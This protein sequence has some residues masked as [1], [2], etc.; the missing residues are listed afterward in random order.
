MTGIKALIFDLDNTLLNFFAFKRAASKAALG[1]M[2]KNGLVVKRA[3]AEKILWS[4]YYQYGFEYRG[5]FQEFLK[6]VGHDPNDLRLVAAAA[7]AYR[8][9]RAH[10][11]KTYPAVRPTLRALRKRG[12]KLWIVTDAPG[13]KAWLRLASTGLLNEFERVITF[14]DTHESK[15]SGKPLEFA[16]EQMRLKPEQVMVV[17]DSGSRDVAPARTLGMPTAMAMYGRVKPP[18]VK[19]D[20][21]LKSVRDLLKI[22]K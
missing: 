13:L 11:L 16:L 17:G 21:E 14:D 6:R 20:Y 5:I 10:A 12:Y 7:V 4:M 3:E 2:I 8:E 9:A 1:A 18:S 22:C 19:A 15:K